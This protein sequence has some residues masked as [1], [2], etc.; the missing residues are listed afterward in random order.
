[1]K[2]IYF[3]DFFFILTILSEVRF[4]KRFQ[5]R[6]LFLRILFL[7]FVLNIRERIMKNCNNLLNL[8]KKTYN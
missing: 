4:N 5:F 3:Y 7:I 1:M 6:I 8:R 2:A